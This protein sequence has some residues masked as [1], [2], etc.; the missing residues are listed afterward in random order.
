MNKSGKTLTALAA[1]AAIAPAIAADTGTPF[2]GRAGLPVADQR[3][4]Q[5]ATT[6]AQAPAARTA[7]VDAGYGRA[8]GV[9][10]EQA[11]R[12]VTSTAAQPATHAAQ[13]YGRAGG[14]APFGG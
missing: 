10:V 12:N 5:I 6:R 3:V 1:F 8:G 14:N 13:A 7:V 2:Y 11:R 9:G 4:Q